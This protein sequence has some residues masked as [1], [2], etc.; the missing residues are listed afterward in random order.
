MAKKRELIRTARLLFSE[1]E[2]TKLVVGPLRDQ[3][4][5]G[6]TMRDRSVAG[7]EMQILVRR[8]RSWSDNAD[9]GEGMQ[10][11]VWWFLLPGDAGTV[12]A[13]VFCLAMHVSAAWWSRSWSAGACCLVMQEQ[14][15]LACCKCGWLL[16]RR[17]MVS[18]RG[19]RE[20]TTGDPQKTF[21][22]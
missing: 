19:C 13:S 15:L 16:C 21:W 1:S 9:A 17:L 22:S 7:I 6:V 4:T 20:N 18:A 14:V 5:V 11:Q 12:A 3:D 8:C 10:M 2:T